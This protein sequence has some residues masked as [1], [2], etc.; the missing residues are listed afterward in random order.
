MFDI[1]NYNWSKFEEDKKISAQIRKDCSTARGIINDALTRYKKK[2]LSARS[3]KQAED[4]A[5]MFKDL[6]LYES[7][8]EIQDAYGYGMISEKE[9]D[10]LN[11]LWDMREKYVDEK[12]VFRDRVT[13]MVERALNSI[14]EEYIDFLTEVEEAERAR[15]SRLR[16]IERE[17]TINDYKKYMEDT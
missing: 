12:G 9:M 15:Q 13:D 8:Q 11:E 2:K 14:G 17:N 3:K 6:E 16:E 10:R 1:E 7:K 5:I 4:M